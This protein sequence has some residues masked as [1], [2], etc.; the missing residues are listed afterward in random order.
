MTTTETTTLNGIAFAS[1]YADNF[2]EHFVFYNE[3]L[4]LEKTMEMDEN[5]CMFKVG[6]NKF[7][8]YL[9][10]KNK[11]IELDAK[12]ARSAFTFSVKSVP[13]FF[14][15]LNEASVKT[16][17]NKPRDMGDGSMWFQF[18]DP[19]GNILEAMGGP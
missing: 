1:I 7:G 13:D 3:V 18:F 6:E 11:K 2:Q 4:G 15:K 12:C 16:V 19:C 5:S 10:G 8:L 14:K 17:Q 9:E